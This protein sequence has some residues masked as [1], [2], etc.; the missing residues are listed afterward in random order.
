[1]EDHGYALLHEIER[2]PPKKRKRNSD[3]DKTRVYIGVAFPRWRQ[4]M[5]E[6]NLKTD[7]EVATFLLDR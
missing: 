7:A 2:K 5:R 4:L 3:R 1:M 6:K